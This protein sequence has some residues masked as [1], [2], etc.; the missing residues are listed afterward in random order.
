MRIRSAR[1][2]RT[3]RRP[4]ADIDDIRPQPAHLDAIHVGSMMLVECAAHQRADRMPGTG[5]AEMHLEVIE[6]ALRVIDVLAILPV[7]ALGGAG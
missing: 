7:I 4:L 6:A 2:G 5:T 3:G 1:S